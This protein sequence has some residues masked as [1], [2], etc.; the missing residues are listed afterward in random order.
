[1]AAAI[2][3]IYAAWM[4]VVTVKVFFMM[5]LLSAAIHGAATG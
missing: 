3:K 1:M 2:A 5:D 4:T